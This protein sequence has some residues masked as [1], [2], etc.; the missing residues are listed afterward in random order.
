MILSGYE[1]ICIEVISISHSHPAVIN[2]NIRNKTN[3]NVTNV[4]FIIIH[5]PKLSLVNFSSFIYFLCG[6]NPSPSTSLAS[7]TTTNASGSSSATSLFIAV[8][9][10]GATRQKSTSLSFPL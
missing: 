8:I 6:I 3:M 2:K 10:C 7:L 4:L 9:C 5:N 1:I